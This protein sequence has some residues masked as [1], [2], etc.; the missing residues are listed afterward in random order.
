MDSQ[1]IAQAWVQR[2]AQRGVSVKLRKNRLRLHPTDAY[3]TLT[4]D[5]LLTFRRHA[6]AI[7]EVVRSGSTPR[8]ESP[9]IG[10]GAIRPRVS[11]A[12]NQTQIFC[13]YCHRATCASD[14]DTRRLLH[15]NDPL[16]AAK[17][18][19][20]ATDQMRVMLARQRGEG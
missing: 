13:S 2:L 18:S 3:S 11:R 10:D 16:E 17:R 5:E 20:F 8:H 19:Q 9:R 14:P 1:Q 12:E 15:W 4:V 7:K 6:E